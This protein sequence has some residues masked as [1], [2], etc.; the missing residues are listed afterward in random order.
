MCNN[1]MYTLTLAI[2]AKFYIYILYYLQV[3]VYHSMYNI[4]E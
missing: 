4:N 3:V 2:I 1:N